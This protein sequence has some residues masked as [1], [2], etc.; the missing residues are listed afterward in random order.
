[1]RFFFYSI[2]LILMFPACQRADSTP[3]ADKLPTKN[4]AITPNFSIILLDSLA[5]TQ[6]IIQDNT[7]D[8]FTKISTLDMSIQMKKNHPAETD[9][10]QIVADYK[11]Y[12]QSD[13]T[14]FTKTETDF[15][16][17]AF[18][19]AVN[20]IKVLN[21]NFLPK[22]IFLIKTTTRHYGKSTYYTRE[23]GI[24]IPDNELAKAD[25]EEF[26][27]VMLHEIFHIYSRQ[28]PK[29]RL[30]LY[31][32]IGFRPIENIVFPIAL[33]Q[34]ILLNP[35]G[36]NTNFGISLK[37]GDSTLTAISLIVSNSA[38]YRADRNAFF[39]YLAFDLY[40]LARKTDGNF[41]VQTNGDWQSPIH[42]SDFP[43]FYQQIGDNTDYIIHPDE[44]LADNFVLLVNDLNGAKRQPRLSEEGRELLMKLKTVLEN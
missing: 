33:Q 7:E 18:L 22:D 15:V 4:I 6:A 36:I 37:S 30:E 31:E 2:V 1:M 13:V 26:T 43:D 3:Q 11:K 27:D 9:R 40:P 19:L 35:D 28:H 44:I 24:I 32:L 5:A 42:Y 17:R 14:Y 39:E 23:N 20:R 41:L 38:T 25:L 21:I 8:F 29:N 10:E 34:R 12:L 16:Q